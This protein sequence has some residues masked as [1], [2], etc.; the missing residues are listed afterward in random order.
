MWV[1]LWLW[2]RLL[3]LQLSVGVAAVLKNVWYDR[4]I[5]QYLNL[6]K[7]IVSISF[8]F[9]SFPSDLL[10]YWENRNLQ[11]PNGEARKIH[12][13]LSFFTR[14]DIQLDSNELTHEA[15]WTGW[16]W[17]VFYIYIIKYVSLQFFV[18]FVSSISV[19]HFSP[20]GSTFES[21]WA[22]SLSA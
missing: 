20:F 1:G 6:L 19:T 17:R 22:I 12:N 3:L 4:F 10:M 15:F 2:L 16:N 8:P 21:I 11:V 18:R 9:L 5:Y 7:L 13:F 14:W